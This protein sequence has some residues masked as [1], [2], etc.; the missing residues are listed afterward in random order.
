MAEHLFGEGLLISSVVFEPDTDVHQ[1]IPSF[2]QILTLRNVG[3]GTASVQEVT[4]DDHPMDFRGALADAPDA[5][6]A[7][8][9]LERELV[10]GE[11][12]ILPEN[13]SLAQSCE[14]FTYR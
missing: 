4:R 3:G 6:F 10:C 9:S 7:I 1:Q 11:L 13:T 5:R 8:P 2:R 12:L 14:Y